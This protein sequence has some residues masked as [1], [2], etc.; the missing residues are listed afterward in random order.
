MTSINKL[1][2]NCFF[3]NMLIVTCHHIWVTSFA[4]CHFILF[5]WVKRIFCTK[6]LIW[7]FRRKYSQFLNRIFNVLTSRFREKYRHSQNL[8]STVLMDKIGRCFGGYNGIKA[9]FESIRRRI[10]IPELLLSWTLR[11]EFNTSVRNIILEGAHAIDQRLCEHD[12]VV[13][14]RSADPGKSFVLKTTCIHDGF[15]AV[16]SN[17]QSWKRIFKISRDNEFTVNN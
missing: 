17:W 6:L 8:P 3:F 13:Q 12:R 5:R 11:L 4:I 14:S 9:S 16:I 2:Q 10:R 15:G 7:F 1:S